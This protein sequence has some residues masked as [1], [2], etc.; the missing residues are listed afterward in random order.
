MPLYITLY[1]FTDQGIRNIKDAPERIQ[2]G[3]KAFEAMGGKM[4]GFYATVGP[5]DYVTIGEAPSD[6]V[7]A[8]FE[9]AIGARG[10]VRSTSM[11]AFTPEE[12]ARVI[13]KLP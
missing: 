11:R 8:A 7:G 6:E 3:I 1:N 5:Y 10:N 12:F 2:D 9:L 13:S 4:L